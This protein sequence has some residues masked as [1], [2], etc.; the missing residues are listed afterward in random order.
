[1]PVQSARPAATPI[2][3]A[4]LAV[5]QKTSVHDVLILLWMMEWG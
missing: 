1:M 2:T 4:S 5:E 3:L